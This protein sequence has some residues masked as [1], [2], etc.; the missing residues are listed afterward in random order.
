MK[1]ED[2]LKSHARWQRDDYGPRVEVLR[3][4]SKPFLWPGIFPELFTSGKIED[5]LFPIFKVYIEQWKEKNLKSVKGEE[6]DNFLKFHARFY[7]NFSGEKIIEELNSNKNLTKVYLP[8]DDSIFC[9]RRFGDSLGIEVQHKNG[10]IHRDGTAMLRKLCQEEKIRIWG[11]KAW[12]LEEF[13]NKVVFTI[14]LIQK[15]AADNS[16]KVDLKETICELTASCQEFDWGDDFTKIPRMLIEQYRSKY[17]GNV[18]AGRA[19]KVQRKI[20]LIHVDDK[21]AAEEPNHQSRRGNVESDGKNGFWVFI[22]GENLFLQIIISGG[23]V[24]SDDL[25][26]IPND[27]NVSQMQNDLWDFSFIMYYQLTAMLMAKRIKK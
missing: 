14:P 20:Q 22:E 24:D 11:R 10:G 8:L 17:P 23:V 19:G 16:R 25:M 4:K 1:M 3:M 9:L 26:S 7:R 21:G 15:S 13:I 6:F 18:S 12:C 5:C 2:V 27:T